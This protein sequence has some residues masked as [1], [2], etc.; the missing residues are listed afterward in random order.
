MVCVNILHGVAIRSHVL[1]VSSPSPV[2]AKDGLQQI[3]VGARR[4]SVDCI[5][6]AHKGAHPR[7]SST[8]LERRQVV[9]REVLRGNDCVEAVSNVSIPVLKIVTR[10]MLASSDD[11]LD[12]WFISPF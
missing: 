8:L 12:R 6:R 10:E 5:V 2:L 11:F 3:A 7:V 4:N 1:I 9:L